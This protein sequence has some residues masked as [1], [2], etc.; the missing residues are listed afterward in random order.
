MTPASATAQRARDV[1][2][3]LIIERRQRQEV[4]IP[5]PQRPW[6]HLALYV[7]L[8]KTPE[9]RVIKGA[10]FEN[11]GCLCREKRLWLNTNTPGEDTQNDP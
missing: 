7:A 5:R 2:I 9:V 4:K 10:R 1:E 3:R 11:G 6:L 8:Q